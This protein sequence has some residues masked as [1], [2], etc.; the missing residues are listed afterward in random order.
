[1]TGKYPGRVGLATGVLRPD[2][3]NGLAGSEVT[4][5]E[6]LKPVGYATGCIGKWHLG[7]MKGMRPM[8]QGF[9]QLLRRAAQPR[10]LGN[11]RTLKRKAA[12]PFCVVMSSKNA[13]PFPPR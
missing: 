9:R 5:A 4:L 12:C 13:P 8:D 3:T 6:V 10:P 11:S 7:F 2:A 1:M